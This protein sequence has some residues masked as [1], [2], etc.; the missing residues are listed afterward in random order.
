MFEIRRSGHLI[1]RYQPSPPALIAYPPLRSGAFSINS[2]SRCLARVRLDRSGTH[3][4]RCHSA[5]G[6]PF[7]LSQAGPYQWPLGPGET[8]FVR[9]PTIG[10]FDNSIPP[11]L[12]AYSPLRSGARSINSS[13]RQS[14]PL[15]RFDL[16]STFDTGS[17]FHLITIPPFPPSVTDPSTPAPGD[18]AVRHT[19]VGTS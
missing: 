12:I 14:V 10:T 6:A 19:A 1:T 4:N 9:D 2:G 8:F 17:L 18:T 5:V 13:T 7:R 15:R 16:I 3:G 11:A